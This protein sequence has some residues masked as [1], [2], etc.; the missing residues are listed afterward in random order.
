MEAKRKIKPAKKDDEDEDD[1]VLSESYSRFTDKVSALGASSSTRLS[2]LSHSLEGML[3]RWHLAQPPDLGQTAH[4]FPHVVRMFA[5]YVSSS[6]LLLCPVITYVR[7]GVSPRTDNQVI[8]WHSLF[9]LC[10]VLFYV[11]TVVWS[12][13]KRILAAKTTEFSIRNFLES[14]KNAIQERS[15]HL[16]SPAMSLQV[17]ASI[18][19][20]SGLAVRDLWAAHNTKRAWAV[21]GTN[22]ECRSGEILLVLGDESAGKTRLLTTLAEILLSPPGLSSSVTR[23][24]RGSVTLGGLDVTKWD[25]PSLQNRVGVLL[26]DACSTTAMAEVLSGMSLEEIL[27]PYDGLQS[28]GPSHSPTRGERACIS[29]ALHITGLNASLLPRLPSKMTTVVTAS[30]EDLKPSSFRARSV[31][32]SPVEWSKVLLARTL[33]QSIFRND[34]TEHNS[35]KFDNCLVGSLLLLDDGT[36]GLSEVDEARL[37]KNLRQTGAAVV[38]TS[39]RW[40]SGRW[41]DKIA[42]IQDGMIVESG[43]HSELISRGPQ[44]SIYASNWHAMTSIV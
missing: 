14:I 37:L 33:S 11:H 38:V 44:K 18:S 29:Q 4:S 7:S 19:P 34:S 6:L 10:V 5:Y 16:E 30:E 9:D 1:E 32:L 23:I 22:L 42:V 15:K 12:A 24:S 21:R 41:A 13:F 8:Q 31:L 20:T 28:V 26:R 39:N 27:D 2:L 25:A 36:S 40:A 3:E 43:T 35:S 17:Q